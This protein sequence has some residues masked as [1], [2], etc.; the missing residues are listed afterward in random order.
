MLFC[1][2]LSTGIYSIMGQC[3]GQV[4]FGVTFRGKKSLL[5]GA[6]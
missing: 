3:M 6:I 4:V 2:T 5:S 1:A